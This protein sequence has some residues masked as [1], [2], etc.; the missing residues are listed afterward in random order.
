MLISDVFVAVTVMVR[1]AIVNL[2]VN[3]R[4]FCVPSRKL[5]G[6]WQLESE[7]KKHPFSSTE[8][9]GHC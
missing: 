2:H 3:D 1:L 8:V 7:K 5:F 9:I 4:L 6:L